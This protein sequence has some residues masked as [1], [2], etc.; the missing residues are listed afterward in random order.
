V[1]S[2]IIPFP[3]PAIE[4]LHSLFLKAVAADDVGIPGIAAVIHRVSILHA[5]GGSRSTEAQ[6][7]NKVGQA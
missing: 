2:N 1:L 7:V 3:M 6:T 4:G 5:S